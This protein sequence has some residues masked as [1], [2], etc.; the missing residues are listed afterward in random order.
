MSFDDTE[1]PVSSTDEIY[2]DVDESGVTAE[3]DAEST[4]AHQADDAPVAAQDDAADTSDLTPQD[5]DEVVAARQAFESDITP[6]EITPPFDVDD[7]ES[8][9]LDDPQMVAMAE[10]F[11]GRW[12]GLISQTNWEK[13]RIIS[14]WRQAL[15]DNGAPATQYSD[16][17]WVRRVGGVTSPHVGRL[18]RV[19]E[20]FGSTYETYEGVYWSHFLAALDWDDAPMWLEGAS[21]ESW[22]V[23]G[24]REKRWQ[25]H[26]AVDSQRPTSSQIVEVDLDEDVVLPAQGGGSERTYDDDDGPGTSGPLSE[27]PDF[28]DADELMSLGGGRE[29][30]GGTAITAE[31]E[32]GDG[33]PQA[34]VQPFANLPKLPDDLNDAVEMLK[35]AILRHKSAGWTEIESD[36]LQR[37]LNALAVL[38]KS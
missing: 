18:R 23:S 33:G 30:E 38:L 22:S 7:D 5:R 9:D 4:D 16:E 32:S 24:M 31:D 6:A 15:I 2:D 10:P 21:K 8:T 12:N 11:V 35:L 37:Y 13:G 17:A 25:A 27:A 20:R 29:G 26:G 19:F 1:R 3:V 14:Q 28:G 34:P 36:D